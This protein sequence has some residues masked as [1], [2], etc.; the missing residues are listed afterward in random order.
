[1][2]MCVIKSIYVST[3]IYSFTYTFTYTDSYIHKY[4]NL[5]TTSVCMSTMYM[6]WIFRLSGI[7]LLNEYVSLVIPLTLSGWQ[8]ITDRHML[9]TSNAFFSFLNTEINNNTNLLHATKMS[10]F[11]RMYIFVFFFFLF[12]KFV[13]RP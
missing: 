12:A 11:I 3:H 13:V 4:Y 8:K 2:C 5:N 9:A 10:I 6:Y 1:M 7:S